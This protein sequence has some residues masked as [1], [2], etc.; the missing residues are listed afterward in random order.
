[1]SRSFWGILEYRVERFFFLVFGNWYRFIRLPFIPALN[2]IQAY[3][4]IEIPYRAE[5]KGGLQIFHPSAGIVVSQFA[6]IGEDVILY[7]GNVIGTRELHRGGVIRIGSR[8]IL[9]ANSVVLGP[10]HIANGCRIGALACVIHD[11]HSEGASLVG[12][13]AKIKEKTF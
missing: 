6:V 8:C 4:N 11:C 5:I 1:M 13:P 9:G 7:G 3:S 12:V 2:L 10:V